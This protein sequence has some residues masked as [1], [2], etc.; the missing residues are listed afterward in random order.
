MA[1][2]DI[3]VDTGDTNASSKAGAAEIYTQARVEELITGECLVECSPREVCY[4]SR[5]RFRTNRVYTKTRPATQKAQK[6][7]EM[8]VLKTSLAAERES[9]VRVRCKERKT[10]K[11][12]IDRCSVSIWK[13]PTFTLVKPL[14]PKVSKEN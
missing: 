6:E 11:F 5:V 10:R 12:W 7:D 3:V 2:G 9:G 8:A 14:A 4:C 13:Y 1:T